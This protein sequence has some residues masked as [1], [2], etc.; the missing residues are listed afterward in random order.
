[1]KILYYNWIQFDNKENVGGGVNIY[2]RN[3][4]EYL[5]NNTT[6]EIYFLSSGWKYNPLNQKPYIHPTNNI[7]KDKC[8]S[9]EII[10][11]SI[12]APAFAIF[13]N[14]QKFIDD[15]ESV[16][17]FDKFIEEH[18]NF[19]VIHINNF[20]GI[21]INILRLKEKYPNTKF[22]ISIHNYQII[23]PLVQYFQNH[24]ECI[25]HDFKNGEE[26]LKCSVILPNKKEYYKRSRN[27]YYEILNNK[28]KFLRLPVKLFCK[29]FKYR[30][31]KYI[32]SSITMLPEQYVR[33]RK[34]NIEYLNKYADSILAVSER[35]RQIMIEHGCNSDIVKTSYIGTKFAEN[36]LMHSI[37]QKTEPFTIAYLGYE[38]IDKGF[39]F[40]IDA[41]SKLDKNV[42][43]DINIVLAVA[44]LHDKNIKK[45]KHFNKI[46]VYK[47]YTHENL[48]DILK[49]VNLGVVPVLWEDNLPQ[50]AIEMVALGVPILCSDFGGASEL[51]NSNLF[52]FNGV[53]ENNFIDKLTNLINSPELLNKYWENHPNLTTME[54]H[55]KNLYHEYIE[56]NQ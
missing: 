54:N 3:L 4:I 1:M 11:S 45:L 29:L 26:C 2:Q 56:E 27:Y 23:C 25:C 21:S 20:E 41:L 47:G 32:G 13:M 5:I 17:I 49:D 10:N 16:E 30:T 12:M 52:K 14:P 38:R 28:F 9:F 15:Q 6:H 51:C 43:K 36:E 48:K 7:F 44:N 42:A 53:N 34:H 35:V 19:D 40:F 37:A 24:N 55:I 33:Y 31:K 50:V 39:F 46:I 8:K 18:G 22:I